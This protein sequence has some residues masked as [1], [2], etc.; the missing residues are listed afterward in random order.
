V[1]HFDLAISGA[2]WVAIG[3]RVFRALQLLPSLMM[4]NS[5][6]ETGV[7]KY[8]RHISTLGTKTRGS[9]NKEET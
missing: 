4:C 1:E 6:V 2:F 8:F 7:E 5:E 3:G 9:G